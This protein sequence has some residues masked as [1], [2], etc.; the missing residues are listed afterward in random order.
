MLILDE[1]DEMLSKGKKI[2]F[3][4]KGGGLSFKAFAKGIGQA[5]SED[6][7]AK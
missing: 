5:A 2:G 6:S 4:G 1:A 3:K 7:P